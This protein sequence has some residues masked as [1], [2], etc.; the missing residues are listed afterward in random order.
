M[1]EF[2]ITD[3]RPGRLFGQIVENGKVLS[4]VL[5]GPYA[6]HTFLNVGHVVLTPKERLIYQGLAGKTLL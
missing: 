4:Q 1:R 2:V 6:V 3:S 5:V